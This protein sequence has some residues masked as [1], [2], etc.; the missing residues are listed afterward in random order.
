MDEVYA[1]GSHCS[2]CG[3]AFP[4]DAA[5]PRTCAFCGN[6]SYRNPLP[7]S[8]ML[9][10]VD[11]GLLVVRRTIEPGR[12][13]LALP[14]GYIN[15]GESWQE[16]GAREVLEETLL[17]LDPAEIREFRVRS[18]PD[19]TLL[20]FGLARPRRAS[21]LPAFS[22]TDEASERLVIQQPAE[23]AF[24]THAEVVREFFQQRARA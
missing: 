8:V 5:W 12:G 18:A 22:P 7:V 6:T 21:D 9:L 17:P 10:P 23:M 20:V 19:G 24:S 1:A 13:K 14:G 3:P 2:Q 15:L 4:L 11:G 16:A